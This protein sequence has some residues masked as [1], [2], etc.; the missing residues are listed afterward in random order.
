MTVEQ[1]DTTAR[2]HAARKAARPDAALRIKSTMAQPF[3]NDLLERLPGGSERY[4]AQAP[5]RLDVMGG[6]A[7]CT[8]SLILNRTLGDRACVGM[9]RQT[10][11]LTL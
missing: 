3:E 11:V 7:E 9:Q 2:R 8:G 4:V 10:R 6:I 1:Q 5:G